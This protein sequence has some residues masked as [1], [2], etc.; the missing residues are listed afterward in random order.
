MAMLNVASLIKHL[1][2]IRLLLY[3][4][5]LDVRA[6]NETRL[7][8]S[9]SDELVAVD[10]YD[11]IRADRNRN[12]GGVCMYIRCHVNYDKRLD[13]VPTDLESV[14]L[15]INQANSRSFIITS[16]YRPPS[17]PVEIFLKIEKLIELLDDKNK[18]VYILGDLNCNMLEPTLL[19]TKKLNEILELYQMRQLINNPTRVTELTQSLLDVCITSNPEH[20][21]HSGVLHLGISDHSLIYAIRKINA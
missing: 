7:D 15:E 3:D 5:K 8:S 13:L 1:D 20:I 18:E 17:A 10:G 14:C 19:P 12:G 4:K 11:L 2:E 6:L 9:I 16:I 21:T